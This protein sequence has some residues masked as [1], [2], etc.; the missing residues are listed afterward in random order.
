MTK[1][2]EK[3]SDIGVLKTMLC[4]GMC[5]IAFWTTI[6][7]IDVIKSAMMADDVDPKFRKYKNM[8]DC[9]IKLYINEGGVFGNITIAGSMYA[10][11]SVNQIIGAR[12]NIDE[13]LEFIISFPFS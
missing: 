8:R 3:V 4:A 2:G 10:R 12:W 7:N 9:A 1:E 5:G 6:Y 13:Q 11:A